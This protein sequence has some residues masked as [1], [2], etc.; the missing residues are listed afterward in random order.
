[1]PF[2]RACFTEH[3]ARLDSLRHFTDNNDGRRSLLRAILELPRFHSNVEL[4]NEPDHKHK[5]QQGP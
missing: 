5:I 4:P 1:M 3:S 2:A